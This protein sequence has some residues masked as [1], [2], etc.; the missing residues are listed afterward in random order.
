MA[1]AEPGLHRARRWAALALIVVAGV[2]IVQPAAHQ[3]ADPDWPGRDE[4]QGQ[5][6]A[7]A[8]VLA[9]VESEL[10]AGE[11]LLYRCALDEQGQPFPDLDFWFDF[12]QAVL[13]PRRIGRQV[14]S[15]FAL[16]HFKQLEGEAT[17][18][19]GRARVLAELAKGLVLVERPES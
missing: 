8:R 19:F 17:P 3:L 11:A 1:S 14:E 2:L 9:P 12:M 5:L 6:D 10:P 15:R 4:F 7:W 13:A 16:E 18:S